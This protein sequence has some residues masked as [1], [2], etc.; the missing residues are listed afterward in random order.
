MERLFIKSKQKT[1][2]TSLTFTRYL[3]DELDEKDRISIIKGA[4]GTGKTTLLLQYAKKYASKFSNILYVSLDDIYFMANSLYDL[5]EEFYKN[6]GQLLLLDEVHKYP[7]WS[8]ELKLIYDDFPHL[9]LLVTSSS[10]LEIYKAESDLSRRTVSYHLKELSF[11]EFLFFEKKLQYTA[12]S[13]EEILKEHENRA[14][15]MINDFKPVYEFNKYVNSGMYPYYWDH[16]AKFHEQLRKTIHLTLEIDLPS[17]KNI[18]YTH[19][20]KLKKLLYAIST[21]AP[22]VP[23]ISKLSERTCISRKAIIKA[24]NYLERGRLITLLNKAN[25]GISSL[26]K[27]DKIFMNNPNLQFAIGENNINTGAVRES[28]FVNQLNGLHKIHVAE[29]GDFLVDEKYI[30]EIGGKNKTKYQIKNIP[31][32][33]I[34]RDDYENGVNNIIPLWLFGFL[35]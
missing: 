19:I 25:K 15:E 23:N 14:L 29:K 32:S 8:R 27:P 24:L 31:N 12:L 20:I 16:K 17:I 13:L 30:F 34:V 4:R 7:N 1:Q 5:A 9:K 22:F 2:E 35:Y 33:Y 10:L 26:S 21:S 3:L 11:R 6:N 18:D 28:F